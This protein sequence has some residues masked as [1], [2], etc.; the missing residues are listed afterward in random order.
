MAD[1]GSLD[2]RVTFQRRLPATRNALNE[3]V[4]AGWAAVAQVW[5]ARTPVLD[6]ERNA[7]AQVSRVVTDRFVTHWCPDLAALTNA[8][9]LLCDDG[10]AFAIVG[11][12]ELGYREGLEFAALATPDRAAP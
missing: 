2:R 12:K 4:D 3:A 6:A 1:L 8:D 5:A 7:G 9:Q 11:K 10:V